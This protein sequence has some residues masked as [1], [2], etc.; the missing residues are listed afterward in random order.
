MGFLC[1]FGCVGHVHYSRPHRKKLEARSKPRILIGYKAGSKAYRMYYPVKQR[2][3]VSCDII[4]D[5]DAQWD[6]SK[7]GGADGFT[8][9]GTFI[10]E[11]EVVVQDL[12]PG[13]PG[14][15]TMPA[16][17][18]S[19][20]Q[21]GSTLA[22]PAGGAPTTPAGGT[23]M[24]PGSGPCILDGLETFHQFVWGSSKL[25]QLQNGWEKPNIWTTKL[26]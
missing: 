3:A 8:S 15:P 19:T 17:S 1:T 20:T 23:P 24:M 13:T 9:S 4:F 14:T 11:Q 22:M 26:H 16:G 10:V 2:I 12:G 5:E 7:A 6:W 21:A 25:Q 18:V